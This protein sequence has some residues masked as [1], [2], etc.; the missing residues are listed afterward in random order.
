MKRFAFFVFLLIS[1]LFA[2]A[3]KPEFSIGVS[4]GPVFSKFKVE[5]EY[6]FGN[7]IDYITGYNTA[8]I[9]KMD[10]ASGVFVET[11]LSFCEH[12]FNENQES[13]LHGLNHTFE[14]S[15]IGYEFEN[16]YR[17][18]NN[19]CFV[20]Y[21]FNLTNKIDASAGIGGYW[22]YLLEGNSKNRNYYYLTAEDAETMGNS[23]LSAG[24]YENISEEPIDQSIYKNFDCGLGTSVSLAYKINSR[25]A[26]RMAGVYRHG[27]RNILKPND[28]W[29]EIYTRS[30]NLTAGVI[31]GF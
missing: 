10:L 5:R 8:V 1:T 9:L 2:F 6:D 27:L 21:T 16:R 14:D 17:Y 29:L 12:G 28:G 24:Y 15:Y 20:G 18:L 30:F 4:G 23:V 3:Q 25:F 13:E 26:L 31:V 7:N 19:M 11:E 22:G